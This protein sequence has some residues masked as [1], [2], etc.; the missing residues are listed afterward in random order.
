MQLS[1]PAVKQSS[2]VLEILSNATALTG[3]WTIFLLSWAIVL[4]RFGISPYLC[5]KL[6]L[7]TIK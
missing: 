2:K 7:R 4:G 3:I 1:F 5:K 6:Q